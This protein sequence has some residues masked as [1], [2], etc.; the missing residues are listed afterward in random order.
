MVREASRPL[1]VAEARANL[2]RA[3]QPP[4]LSGGL[5]LIRRAPG[6]AMFLAFLAG[7]ALAL[8]TPLQNLVKDI[9]LGWLGRSRPAPP[10]PVSTDR[11]PSSS[12]AYRARSNNR[13]R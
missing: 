12:R 13:F 5:Q 3:M 6:Q 2:R 4:A 7:L 10:R 8:S 9:L 1:T 11:R